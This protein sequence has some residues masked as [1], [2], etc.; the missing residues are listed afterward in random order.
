MASSKSSVF[1][2]T[3]TESIFVLELYSI[4]VSDTCKGC[5][6][7]DMYPEIMYVRKQIINI[8]FIDYNRDAKRR[9]TKVREFWKNFGKGGAVKVFILYYFG[10]LVDDGFAVWVSEVL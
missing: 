6:N 10:R 4:L 7:K 5:E 8:E 2:L 1:T 3:A 9:N